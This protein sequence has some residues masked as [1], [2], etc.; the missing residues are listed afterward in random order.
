MTNLRILLILSVCCTAP[1]ACPLMAQTGSISGQVVTQDQKP[2]ASASVVYMRQ[3]DLILNA[4]R[5]PE[6]NISTAA[7]S[8]VSVDET[9][10]FRI[11]GLPPGYYYLCA[12]APDPSLI[13]SCDWLTSAPVI[14]LSAGANLTGQVLVL[15]TGSQLHLSVSDPDGR[16]AA[17]YIFAAGVITASGYYMPFKVQ[18]KSSGGAQYGLLVPGDF[19]GQLLVDTPLTA[20][21]AQGVVPTRVPSRAITMDS[22][23]EMTIK[24]TVK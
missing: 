16:L 3:L 9:G 7:S 5:R 2:V 10:A 24:L 13:R 6:G 19:S 20:T 14:Q 15:R 18:S 11:A 17:R 23:T 8:T 4:R 1:T 12:S 22:Q 21:D